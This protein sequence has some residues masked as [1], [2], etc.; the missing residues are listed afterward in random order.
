MGWR[1]GGVVGNNSMDGVD[2]KLKEHWRKDT[3]D[4]PWVLKRWWGGEGSFVAN[5]MMAN[6]SLF[7]GGVI[8]NNLI[9]GLKKGLKR[10]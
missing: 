9:V 6:I 2:N 1:G 7:S 4:L 10:H 3:G 5:A 8:S